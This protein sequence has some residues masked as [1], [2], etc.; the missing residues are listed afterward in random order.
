MF[1]TDNQGP[2]NGTCGLKHLM[3]G[4]FVGHPDGNKW[5]RRDRTCTNRGSRKPKSRIH[6]E[7]EKIPATR[8]AGRAVP[9]RQDGQVGERHRHATRRGGKFGPFAEQ[10]FVGDQIAQHRDAR[11]PGKGERPLSRRLLPVP[12]GLRLGHAAAADGTRRLAVRR[13]HEPRLGLARQQAV[14]LERLVWTGKVPFEIHEMRAKPDGFELTFTEPVDSQA[15]GDVKSYKLKTYTYIY[16][17]DYGSPEVDQTKPTITKVEVSADKK[18]VRLFVDKLQRGHVHE[19][20]INVKNEAGL[21]LLHNTGY[22]TM[23]NIP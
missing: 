2:W 14:R 5:Y 12:P 15:A 11:V 16:Q 18:T 13:R 3:P 19:L 7:A 17:S 6:I 9:L 1:Y 23:N 4:T 20:Q 10:L 22:Y 8:A 21:P